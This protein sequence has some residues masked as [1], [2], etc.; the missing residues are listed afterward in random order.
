MCGY[1]TT[2]QICRVSN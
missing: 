2:Q 1:K